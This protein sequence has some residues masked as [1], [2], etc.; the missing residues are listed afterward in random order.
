MQH[1]IMQKYK[2]LHTKMQLAEMNAN[3]LE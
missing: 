2:M 3:A 1:S